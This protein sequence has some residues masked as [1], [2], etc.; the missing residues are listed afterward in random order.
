MK[1]KPLTKVRLRP[2]EKPTDPGVLWL[3]A[4]GFRFKVRGDTVYLVKP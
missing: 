2:D 4:H 1:P 3:I